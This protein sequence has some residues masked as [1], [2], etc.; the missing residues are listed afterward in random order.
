M[1]KI[2][3]T[4][5]ALGGRSPGNLARLA[6]G[7]AIAGTRRPFAMPNRRHPFRWKTL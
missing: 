3:Q 4:F 5:Q 2:G 6:M 7:S 1:T